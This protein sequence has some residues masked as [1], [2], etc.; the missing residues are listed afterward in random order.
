MAMHTGDSDVSVSRYYEKLK[1]FI[2]TIAFCFVI[3][4]YTIAKELK[5]SVFVSI[6]GKMYLPKAKLLVVLFFIPATLLYSVLVDRLRRYQLL[7]FYCCLYGAL[8]LLFSYLLGHPSIGLANTDTSPWRIFGWIFYFLLEGFSPFVV[9]VFWSF[10]NSI[11][12]PEEAK[13]NYASMVSGSK[14]GGMATAL[15]AWY[16]MTHLQ[17]FSWCNMTEVFAHQ[18]ILAVVA[19]MLLCVPLILKLMFKFVPGKYLHGY[20]AVYQEE[21][22]KSKEGQEKTGMFSG[23]SLIMKSPYILGIFSLIFFYEMLNVILG[24]QRIALLQDAS[25]CMA[26]F[27]G[28]MF[29]QR[30]QMHLLGWVL[31]FFGVRLLVRRFGEKVSLLL[32]PLFI[33]LLLF[34][35][36]MTQ[37]SDAILYVFIGL[38]SI[39]YSFSHPLREALYIPTLKDMKFKA[40]SWIDTFGNK[41]SKSVGSLIIDNLK[42]IAPHTA[43]FYT[44]FGS[45]FA[46]IIGIW[47]L[48]AWLLGTRYEKAIK[49]NEVIT[50]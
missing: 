24:F 14:F 12:S 41:I 8:L 20:E 45:L 5:D 27:T 32:V 18:F 28:A 2:M 16:L 13:Y 17:E 4:S 35:F 48:V 50:Q 10:A 36:M 49:N 37:T 40:K 42:Y 7:V 44:V 21:K 29:F 46:G 39:N 11:T 19:G 30:F 3:G 9:S 22:Q 38:G 6:V 47:F 43:A 33:G 23:L 31:S 26:D 1:F 15:L 34:Y 25:S